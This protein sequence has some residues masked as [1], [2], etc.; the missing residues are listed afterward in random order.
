M[1][2]VSREEAS[3]VCGDFREMLKRERHHNHNIVEV[4]GILRWEENKIVRDLVGV[5]GKIDLNDLWELFYAMGLD[6][7]SEFVRDIYRNMG[8]SLFGFWEL[9]YW[10]VNN[11]KACEYNPTQLIRDKRL[12]DILE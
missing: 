5:S 10:D 4:D 8:Y 11:E 12:G 7:N 2:I 9:F 6:R 3:G 1:R